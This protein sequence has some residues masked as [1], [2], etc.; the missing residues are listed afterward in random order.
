MAAAVI[1][2]VDDDAEKLEAVEAAL[3]DRYGRHY[4]VECLG[5]ALEAR[6]RLDE[7]RQ[8]GDE[9]ALVLCAPELPEMSGSQLLETVHES[10]PR[11]RRALLVDWAEWGKP[12]TGHAIFSGIANGWFDHYVVEP[13]ATLDEQFHTSI[14][15]MLLAWT[16]D[17]DVAPAVSVVGASWSGRAYEI[18]EALQACAMPHRFRLAESEEGRRII[19][20]AGE[21]RELPIMVFPNGAVMENPTNFEIASAAGGAVTPTIGEFDLVVIGAGPAGLSAAV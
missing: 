11:A 3:D 14:S 20:A 9:V 4:R 5:T 19:A 12:A 6:S 7:V 16:E 18:R 8:A 21:H 10:H 2:V 17:S 15:N 13:V 1:L